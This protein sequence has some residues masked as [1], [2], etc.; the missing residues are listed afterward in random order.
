MINYVNGNNQP[1]ATP[2][3]NA[4]TIGKIT[5]SND[6]YS[7]VPSG[8]GANVP[9]S[10]A[11][12]MSNSTAMYTGG[13]GIPVDKFTFA[14]TTNALFSSMAYSVPGAASASNE[15]NGYWIGGLPPSGGSKAQKLSFT[16]GTVT[17]TPAPNPSWEVNNQMSSMATSARSD[18]NA[19]TSGPTIV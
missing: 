18:A 8:T 10:Y 1:S 19:G 15:E 11:R 2:S 9:G 7:T 3:Y 6:T 12:A 5:Y 4:T 13:A 17:V 16:S 14:T